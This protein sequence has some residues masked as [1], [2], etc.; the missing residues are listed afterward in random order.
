M[1]NKLT[2]V[3]TTY[4]RP[5]SLKSAI[6]SILFQSFKYFKLVILDNGSN[7]ETSNL[8]MS[9]NDNRI[10]YIKNDVNDLEFLNRA[11]TF[12]KLKYLMITHDDDTMEEGLIERHISKMDSDNR[13]GLI[14]SSINLI[15]NQGYKLNKVRPRLKKDKRWTKEQFIQDYFFKGDIIPCPASIFR[16]SIIIENKF[17]YEWKVGPAVDLY[18]LFKINMLNHHIYLFKKPLYNYRIHQKQDSEKNRILLEYKVRPHIV[19]LLTNKNL[20]KY[21]KKYEQASLGIILQIIL[22]NFFIG[23]F[24]FNELK[25]QINRLKNEGLRINFISLYWFLFGTMRGLK[26]FLFR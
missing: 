23:V 16:S 25:R 2:I 6:D 10:E 12:T 13:I 18:L 1:N 11:F 7:K 8:I 17:N 19:K 24:S 5:K 14:S 26:N 20:Y 3:L 21:V 15:N 22:N 4:N 9:Y